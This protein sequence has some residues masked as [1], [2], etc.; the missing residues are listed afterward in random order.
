MIWSFMIRFLP[1]PL[2]R[3]QF[4][5]GRNVAPRQGRHDRLEVP[6]IGRHP[7]APSA[8]AWAAIRTSPS[9]AFGAA[10]TVPARRSVAQS[11]AAAR[12]VDVVAMGM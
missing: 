11:F 12:Q 6:D 5:Q 10:V 1:Q 7:E 9:S 4:L 2:F 8:R 3:E